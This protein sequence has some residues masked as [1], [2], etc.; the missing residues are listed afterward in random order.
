MKAIEDL[1]YIAFATGTS[2][3]YAGGI[4]EFF[5]CPE[6]VGKPLPE[7]CKAGTAAGANDVVFLKFHGLLGGEADA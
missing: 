5:K 1:H 2:R 7:P 6:A 3:T 4:G